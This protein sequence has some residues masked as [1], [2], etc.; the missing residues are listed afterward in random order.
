MIG[1]T[2]EHRQR[3]RIRLE[4]GAV[5][6][7]PFGHY[8]PGSRGH[9]YVHGPDQF[10]VATIGKRRKLRTMPWLRIV[11]DGDDGFNG[12]FPADRLKTVARMIGAYRRPRLSPE[13]RAAL[14]ERMRKTRLL[15]PANARNEKNDQ[16][17]HPDR[18]DAKSGPE[19]ALYAGSFRNKRQPNQ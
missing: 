2:N 14:A 8:I 15:A 10:G 7:D 18:L 19:S 13:Q 3:F 12:V 1:F 11:Q 9:I 6:S 5:H 17:H 16:R 4:E